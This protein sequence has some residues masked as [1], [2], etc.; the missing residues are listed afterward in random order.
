L[1][2]DLVRLEPAKPSSDGLGHRFFGG[3]SGGDA[4][5][6]TSTVVQFIFGEA[7]FQES[8]GAGQLKLSAQCRYVAGIDAQPQRRGCGAERV[9]E[10][11]NGARD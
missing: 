11:P 1:D 3:P 2:L 6:P 10:Q 5:G 8:G 4:L 7:I 9:S